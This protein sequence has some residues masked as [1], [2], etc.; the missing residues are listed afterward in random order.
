MLAAV[1]DGGFVPVP[2]GVLIEDAGGLTISTVGISGD[3]SEKDE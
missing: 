1:V 3:N 2:S